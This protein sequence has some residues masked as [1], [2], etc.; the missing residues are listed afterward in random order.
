MDRGFGGDNA[1]I[2]MPN[3]LRHLTI[4]QASD[5]WLI[6]ISEAGLSLAVLSA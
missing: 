3:R 2:F 6:L 1:A 5:G 4:W